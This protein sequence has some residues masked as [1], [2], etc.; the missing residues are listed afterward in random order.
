MFGFTKQERTVLSVFALIII[1]GS[2]I[3][4]A[5]KRYPNLADTVNLIDNDQIVHKTDINTASIEELIAIPYI[6]DYTAKQIVFYRQEKGLF[7]D[8]DQLKLI[9]GIKAKNFERFAKYL[10]ISPGR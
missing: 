10:K 2:I 5:F 8:L 4:F 9:K 6:G 3:E 7:T 1:F